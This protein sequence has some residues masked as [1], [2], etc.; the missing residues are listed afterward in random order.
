MKSLPVKNS[1]ISYE[2]KTPEPIPDMNA[3]A[4][5]IKEKKLSVYS[6]QIPFITLSPLSVSLAV[7][8]RING[9]VTRGCVFNDKKDNISLIICELDNIAADGVGFGPEALEEVL[10]PADSCVKKIKKAT[11]A[12]GP[13]C[14]KVKW[15]EEAEKR[16]ADIYISVEFQ[17]RKG[18]DSENQ[19][20]TIAAESVSYISL[21]CLNL[22]INEADYILKKQLMKKWVEDNLGIPVVLIP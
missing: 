11:I 2:A 22:P 1:G 17:D 7:A 10:E 14:N 21:P 19:S 18:T 20:D 15:K 13:S 12:A 5:K 16:G 3:Y 8:E 6:C 9:K 4:E